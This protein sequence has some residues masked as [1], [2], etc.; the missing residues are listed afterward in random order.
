MGQ[1]ERRQRTHQLCDANESVASS[2]RECHGEIVLLA[3]YSARAEAEGRQFARSGP[4]KPSSC[5]PILAVRKTLPSMS[6]SRLVM[7]R[8]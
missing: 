4:Q 7:T 8:C 2:R 1:A 6:T 5:K 3:W